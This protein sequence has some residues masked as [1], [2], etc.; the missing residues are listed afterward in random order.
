[1]VCEGKS[2]SAKFIKILYRDLYILYKSHI[3]RKSL[4]I[5]QRLLKINMKI[6]M[7]IIMKINMKINIDQ[8]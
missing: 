1:M 4:E 5:L 8:G 7:K 6:D 2:C 3:L